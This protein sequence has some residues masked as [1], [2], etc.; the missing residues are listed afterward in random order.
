M[1][2]VGRTDVFRPLSQ[3]LRLSGTKTSPSEVD[4]ERPVTTVLDT[5]RWAERLGTIIVYEPFTVTTGGGGA[6]VFSTRTEADQRA[7][8]PLANALLN[9]G[10]QE[11]NTDWWLM[12][13]EFATST[14]ST[15]GSVSASIGPPRTEGRVVNL[16]GGVSTFDTFLG[17]ANA[18]GAAPRSGGLANVHFD[19]GGLR[20]P[21]GQ[22]ASKYTTLPR[23]L[24][25][26]NIRSTDQGAGAATIA[27]LP[28]YAYC[29]KGVRPEL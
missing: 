19:Q 11:G 20:W 25:Q 4:I 17:F 23:Q 15:F 9:L 16:V 5:A 3:L 8:A 26:L 21:F 28:I 13:L 18:S 10:L 12:S 2:S 27:V 29:P 1:S 22:D 7:N 24:L 6:A 14:P